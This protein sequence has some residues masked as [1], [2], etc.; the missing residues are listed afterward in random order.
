MYARV[1]LQLVSASKSAQLIRRPV[2]MGR[3][4]RCLLPADDEYSVVGRHGRFSAHFGEQTFF[5]F[6]MSELFA[7]L[8]CAELSRLSCCWLAWAGIYFPMML[9]LWTLQLVLFAANKL[10]PIDPF[11]RNTEIVK[12]FGTIAK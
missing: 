12:L 5:P 3:S 4:F 6:L 8:D 2:S 10:V 11:I 1:S 7:A 9:P